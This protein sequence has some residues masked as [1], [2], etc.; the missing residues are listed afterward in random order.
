MVADKL[1][2]GKAPLIFKLGP[3]W[4]WVVRLSPLATLLP[5]KKLWISLS[6]LL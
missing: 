4:M 1:S 2:V 5:E 6:W 3:M